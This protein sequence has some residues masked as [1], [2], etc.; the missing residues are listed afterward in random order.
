MEEATHELK[1][2]P[3]ANSC[4]AVA[5]PLLPEAQAAISSN[6]AA[7]RETSHLVKGK[8]V[9]VISRTWPGIN[10]PGGI[11]KITKVYPEDSTL[12]VKCVD[13]KY[14]VHGGTDKA[15]PIEFIEPHEDD[16]NKKRNS[17]FIRRCTRCKSFVSDCLNCDLRYEAEEELRRQREEEERRRREEK[18]ADN[19]RN[20]GIDNHDEDDDDDDRSMDSEEEEAH[21]A[22]I[23]KRYRKL[24]K[25][26]KRRSSI[27]HTNPRK[28]LKLKKT[29]QQEGREEEAKTNSYRDE[30]N[31]LTKALPKMKKK[32]KKK[33]LQKNR[34]KLLQNPSVLASLSLSTNDIETSSVHVSGKSANDS[35]IENGVDGPN[36]SCDDEEVGFMFTAENDD[37]IPVAMDTNDDNDSSENGSSDDD[38]D[39]CSENVN[40]FEMDDVQAAQSNSGGSDDS[41]DDY[42]VKVT[43][44]R[45][46]DETV[47]GNKDYEQDE[48]NIIIDNLTTTTIRYACS[49]LSRLQGVL[50]ELKRNMAKDDC[51]DELNELE[52]EG[53][54]FFLTL[55]LL[56]K[57]N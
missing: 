24:C 13:V 7:A 27:K 41:D 17:S 10:K 34:R 46:R 6:A 11:G 53:C 54:V 1:E 57:D 8:L 25:E 49:E 14:I 26:A 45:H 12:I 15:I 55:H 50:T 30:E 31:D 20:K 42:D 51:L 52:K 39:D 48:I 18:M 44:L 23:R 43:D 47:V 22:S 38:L 21:M 4:N 35:S 56:V 28:Q 9:N 16:G 32:T 29:E 5:A 37:E 36:P 3:A 19:F 40:N 2:A 33:V